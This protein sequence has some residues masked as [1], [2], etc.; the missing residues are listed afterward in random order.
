MLFDSNGYL[1][2]I[3]DK[4]SNSININYSNNRITSIADT[5]QRSITLLYDEDGYLK[6]IRYRDVNLR[7]KATKYS[8]DKTGDLLTAI[9]E[10]DLTQSLYSYN[11]ANELSMI[12]SGY[13]NKKI[14]SR[15]Q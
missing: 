13:K 7:V 8:Y 9:T 4:N 11:T 6:E 5:S 15:K 2:R 10:E 12:K 3:T 14:H 1:I